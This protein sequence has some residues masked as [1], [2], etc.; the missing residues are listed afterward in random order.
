MDEARR[1][2]ADAIVMRPGK[3]NGACRVHV[4]RSCRDSL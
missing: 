3:S 4:A 2:A 1:I